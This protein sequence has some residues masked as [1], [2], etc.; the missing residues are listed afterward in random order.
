MK[1]LNCWRS[2]GLGSI[3]DKKH[4]DFW[5]AGLTSKCA[6]V[7]SRY[8]GDGH[9]TFNRNPC[10]WYIKPYYWVDD[11]PLLYGNNGSLDPSTNGEKNPNPNQNYFHES[12][13]MFLCVCVTP[14]LLFV[15]LQGNVFTA[16][17]ERKN[18]TLKKLIRL[19]R[20]KKS[21]VVQ[22]TAGLHSSK[23][24]IKKG[25]KHSWNHQLVIQYSQLAEYF[26]KH[27]ELQTNIRIGIEALNIIIT[28]SC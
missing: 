15:F 23:L 19:Y 26:L 4:M 9:H 2:R 5:T 17:F 24:Q 10:N 12:V 14:R 20:S 27:M 8:I 6:M 1:I 21:S 22:S 18:V 11:H 3:Q 16:V 25:I 7:K 28:S 13:A